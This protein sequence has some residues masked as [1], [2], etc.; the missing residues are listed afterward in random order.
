MSLSSFLT[1][2]ALALNSGYFFASAVKSREVRHVAVQQLLEVHAHL[3]GEDGREAHGG[4]LVIHAKV[5]HD[6]TGKNN[7]GPDSEETSYINRDMVK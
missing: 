5:S 4:K 7:K 1:I 3:E 2:L 6:G